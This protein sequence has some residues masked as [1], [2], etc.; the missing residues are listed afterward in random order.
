MEGLTTIFLS[1]CFT[2]LVLAY[3]FYYLSLRYWKKKDF[4]DILGWGI[5]SLPNKYR[6][7]PEPG[8]TYG[9]I[10]MVLYTLFILIG[11][12]LAATGLIRLFLVVS[13]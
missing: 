1:V 7:L 12:L 10:S 13:K 2:V 9:K 3:I 11:L 6:K 4:L 8:R 5:L